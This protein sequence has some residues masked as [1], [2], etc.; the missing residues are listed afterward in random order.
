M[1]KTQSW[2]SVL[3]VSY[4]FC[5]KKTREGQL[6]WDLLIFIVKIDRNSNWSTDKPHWWVH[7]SRN[8]HIRQIINI[9]MLAQGRRN[10]NAWSPHGDH[11]INACTPYH[12]YLQPLV[13]SPQH[14]NKR[15][16]VWVEWK[17]WTGLCNNS[18]F[19][20]LKCVVYTIIRDTHYWY[21]L[22]LK[23]QL[24]GTLHTQNTCV[25]CTVHTKQTYT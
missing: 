12:R 20:M 24:L 18:D 4:M 8:P 14:I 15:R 22:Q 17:G 10:V 1:D 25:H 11:N 21:P 16:R 13:P 19:N 3:I 9:V 5:G 2:Y 23:P 7:F 6:R